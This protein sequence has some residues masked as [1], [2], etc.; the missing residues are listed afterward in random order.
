M[1]LTLK[2]INPSL[3][4]RNRV[5]KKKALMAKRTAPCTLPGVTG[6]ISCMRTI[7]LH[8]CKRALRR[9]R[10]YVMCFTKDN[11]GRQAASEQTR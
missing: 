10:G 11:W 8:G 9:M 4:L 3:L 5:L 2:L 1:A 6:I 7:D